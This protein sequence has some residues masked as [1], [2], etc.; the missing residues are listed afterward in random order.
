VLEFDKA[1]LVASLERLHERDRSA[2]AAACAQ[3]V[4]PSYYVFSENTGRGNPKRLAE[5]I[6]RLWDDLSGKL[7][8]DQEV[9]AAIQDCLKLIPQEGDGP[10]VTEQGAAD[11]SVSALAYALRCRKNGLAKEAAWAAE[12]AYEAVMYFCE[13]MSRENSSRK[14]RLLNRSQIQVEIA[15]R[16]AQPVVQAELASQQRD[17]EELLGNKATPR[18]LQER[19]KLEAPDLSFR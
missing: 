12:R 14:T 9:E 3:R 2:F 4:I 17:L 16:A 13:N 5:L 10:W 6:D 11:D 7:M 8:S 18:L 1:R 19:A 15:S